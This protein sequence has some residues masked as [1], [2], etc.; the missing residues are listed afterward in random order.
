MNERKITIMTN[1]EFLNAIVEA[2]VNDEL[3]AFALAEIEK[4]DHTN[5]VR[6][7]K[8]AEKAVEK[9][10]EKE[11]LRQAIFACVTDEPKT[12]TML[13]DEAGLDLKPQSIPSL[14]KGLVEAGQI[15]KVDVKIKGKG[16]QRGYVRA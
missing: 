10:A 16:T 13:I 9:A 4:L 7:A 14:L 11:P 1:R 6:R 8:M 2:N 3:T 15:N 5:E 12:A